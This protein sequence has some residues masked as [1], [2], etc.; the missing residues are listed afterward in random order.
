M[1]RNKYR[2][3]DKNDWNIFELWDYPIN[4]G[5]ASNTLTHENFMLTLWGNFCYYPHFK[6]AVSRPQEDYL[7]TKWWSL[8]PRTKAIPEPKPLTVTTLEYSTN[9]ADSHRSHRTG[10]TKQQ[11]AIFDKLHEDILEEMDSSL[12]IFHFTSDIL[13]IKCNPLSYLYSLERLYL[14]ASKINKFWKKLCWTSS[15]V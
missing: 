4:S 13:H 8:G 6:D 5:H 1:D 10:S 11:K 7:V 12:R 15:P 9:M 3:N 14:H 2:H